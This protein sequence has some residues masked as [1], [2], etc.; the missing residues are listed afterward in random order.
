MIVLLVTL[1]K[2]T[3]SCS[4]QNSQQ[5][6]RNVNQAICLSHQHVASYSCGCMLMTQNVCNLSMGL[7]RLEFNKTMS[8]LQ[9]K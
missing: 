6:S 7:E 3:V 4:K 5:V 2:F 1:G 8:M 9:N